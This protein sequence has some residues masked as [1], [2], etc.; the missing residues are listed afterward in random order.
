MSQALIDDLKKENL[1]THFILPF[2]KVGKKNFTSSG[3]INS[4]LTS[5][6]KRIAVK[7]ADIALLSR[8]VLT[9]PEFVAIYKDN[10][11]L[12][13]LMFRLRERWQDDVA[14]FCAGKYSK[15]SS[16]AKEYI[17]RYSGLDYRKKEGNRVVTDGRL[18]ALEKHK[19]L[20]GMWEKEYFTQTG[21]AID[22]PEI[23]LPD[24]YLS[25]PGEESYIS[26]EGLT[27]VRETQL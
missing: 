18:L 24:D 9:H 21:K 16:K 23:H 19:A 26:P 8:T 12:Y 25:V 17:I 6:R 2:L 27:R 14:L 15:L 20:R 11:G 3:F 5:D 10:D 7:L 1:C 4:Y 22:N 13:L